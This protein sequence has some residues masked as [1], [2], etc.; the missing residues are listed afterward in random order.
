MAGTTNGSPSSERGADENL[1]TLSD[2]EADRTVLTIS[3]GEAGQNAPKRH[4]QPSNKRSYPQ[5]S[6]AKRL[7]PHPWGGFAVLG[8][9][10]KGREEFNR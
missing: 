10:R 1:A 9:I 2:L 6:S 3:L 4:W 8:K 7:N 5:R